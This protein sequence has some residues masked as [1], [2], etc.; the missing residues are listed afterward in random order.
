[1]PN[2]NRNR[3]TIGGAFSIG[4][5]PGL[6]LWLKADAISGLTDG[7][8][9]STWTD[10]SGRGNNATQGT[11]GNQPLYKT[12]I[13][14]SLPGVLFDGSNDFMATPNVGIG[15]FSIFVVFKVSGTAG[16]FYEHS[17]NTN[18]NSGSYLYGTTI[19]TIDVRRIGSVNTQSQLSTNWAQ[20]NAVKQVTHLFAGTFDNNRLRINGAEQ[21]LTHSDANNPGTGVIT[22][23]V[24]VG[25]RSGGALPMNGYLFELVICTPTLSDTLVARVEQLLRTKWGTP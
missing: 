2:A 5:L 4:R 24:Y 16:L 13:V 25:A 22:D 6:L 23:A 11:G 14:G 19:G 7:A 10:S 9:L 20:D 17:A 3:R 12:S 21:S 18:T 8:A 15:T 1:M